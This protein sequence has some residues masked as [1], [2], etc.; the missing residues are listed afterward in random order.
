LQWEYPTR[1]NACIL[2]TT[3]VVLENGVTSSFNHD[4]QMT[5]ESSIEDVD[6]LSRR[7]SG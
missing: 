5:L 1:N 3:T 7:R 6:K 4:L 2:A